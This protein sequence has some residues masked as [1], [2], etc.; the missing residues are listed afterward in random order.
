MNKYEQL[1]EFLSMCLKLWWKP[2]W[3]IESSKRW[4]I[5]VMGNICFNYRDDEYNEGTHY[6]TSY[7]ELF[8]KDSSLMEFVD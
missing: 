6:I 2:F 1:Q 8:S 5:D 4:K 3:R 7:H